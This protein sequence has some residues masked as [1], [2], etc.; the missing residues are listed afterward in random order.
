MRRKVKGRYLK[1]QGIKIRSSG[2]V[3]E[4]L[5]IIGL[6]GKRS[7]SLCGVFNKSPRMV[8]TLL[9]LSGADLTQNERK[10]KR[11]KGYLLIACFVNQ[12]VWIIH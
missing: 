11:E 4:D 3:R 7:F 6:Q 12:Y 9:S 1:S 5:F 2:T 8:Y 10:S